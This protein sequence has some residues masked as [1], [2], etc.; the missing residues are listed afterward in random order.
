MS[1]YLNSFSSP[2]LPHQPLL[3]RSQRPPRG[4]ARA[5]RCRP[6]ARREGGA[7]DILGAREVV[8]GGGGRRLQ[9]QRRASRRHVREAGQGRSREGQG[10]VGEARGAGNG[11]EIAPG[12][13]GSG[14]ELEG[15]K[16]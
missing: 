16:G 11:G 1:K 4:Q 8:C 6:R 10:R 13:A 2:P 7:A 14:S 12:L 15:A 3:L 5:G 9:R